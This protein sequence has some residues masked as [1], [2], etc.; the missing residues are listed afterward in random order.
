MHVLLPLLG[1]FAALALRACPHDT[2]I[3]APDIT[4][5][6]ALVSSRGGD[7]LA[8]IEWEGST[9]RLYL[10]DLDGSNRVRVSFAH[11][12]DHVQGNYSP[13][14]LPV[15]DETLLRITRVKWSPD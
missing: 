13:R 8:T 4:P 11:V 12:S 14:Q 3:T 6:R 9:P 1:S 2:S 10:Q 15:T 5:T 7:R